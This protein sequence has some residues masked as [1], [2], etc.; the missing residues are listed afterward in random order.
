MKNSRLLFTNRP[1]EA[2]DAL[3][4][5]VD[6]RG[7]LFVIADTNTNRLVVDRLAAQS[8][9]IA[10]A[11]RI[12]IEPGDSNKTVEALAAVWQQMSDAGAT[13]HA[14]AVNIG[15]GV[16]TDLGGMAAATFKRGIEFIN[17]PTTLLGAVDA[18]V[19]GKTGVNLGNL[20]NEVGVFAPATAVVISA[21]FFDTLPTSE[22][23]SG[24]G[25]MIKHALLDSE[26]E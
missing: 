23:L 19:G 9:R 4:A 3:L 1:A 6:T 24:Y 21:C 7:G 2:L 15:G 16:V 10:D 8:S 17:V 14:V 12:V 11:R 26:E 5:E 22:L 13:R 25:E 18:A 20:K